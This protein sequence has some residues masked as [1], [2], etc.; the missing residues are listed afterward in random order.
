MSESGST[1]SYEEILA[2]NAELFN[3]LQYGLKVI[4][5]APCSSKFEQDCDV[6]NAEEFIHAAIAGLK[7]PQSDEDILNELIDVSG[8][9]R[10][11]FTYCGQTYDEYDE[12]AFIKAILDKFTLIRKYKD[13]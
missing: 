7:R 8:D 9:Y 10:S 3:A 2:I 5:A 6:C 12:I 4:K 11:Q 13:E 1:P